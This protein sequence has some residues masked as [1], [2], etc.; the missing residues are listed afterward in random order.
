VGKYDPLRD[1]LAGQ[2]RDEEME[3]T[4]G[5]VEELV[6]RLPNSARVHRPWWAN[7]SKVE[8]Q[9]WRAAGWHVQ[10]VNMRSEQVTFARGAAIGRWLQD[11][12][13]IPWPDGA[14]PSLEMTHRGAN[15]FN[16]TRPLRR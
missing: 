7:G 10:E 16:V 14:P 15:R 4:F 2:N 11:E 8:A 9:A 6:G 1:Y 13:L 12:R 3:M 5:E